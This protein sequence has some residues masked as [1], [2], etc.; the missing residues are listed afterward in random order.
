M[1][2]FQRLAFLAFT[3]PAL[4][5]LLAA[6]PKPASVFTDHAVFRFKKVN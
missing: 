1:K 2:K 6:D 3:F 4:G 5:S